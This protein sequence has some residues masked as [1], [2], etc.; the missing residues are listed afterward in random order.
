MA[1]AG[2]VVVADDGAVTGSGVARALYDE[3][4][5]V[6]PSVLTPPS[7]WG[8][9]D[10]LTIK[11]YLAR[12]ANAEAKGHCDHGLCFV[13]MRVGSSGNVMAS[14]GVPT[15]VS[16]DV[17]QVGAG[18]FSMA[19]NETGGWSLAGGV[20]SP[21]TAGITASTALAGSVFDVRLAFGSSAAPYNDAFSAILTLVKA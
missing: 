19:L 7:N 8:A 17:F 16:L 10:V 9:A 21:Y 15:D 11:R 14:H 1:T 5:A 6:E 13:F 2:S 12:L 3:L 4:V 20:V 18:Y